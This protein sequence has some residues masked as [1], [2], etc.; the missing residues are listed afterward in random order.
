MCHFV[1]HFLSKT[2]FRR[3]LFIIVFESCYVPLCVTFL[4]ENYLS[5]F[6]SSIYHRFRVLLC[7]T[8][9]HISYRKLSIYFSIFYLSSFSI[10]KSNAFMISSKS[11]FGLSASSKLNP[12]SLGFGS[13]FF[14]IR[15]LAN[16]EF[17]SVSSLLR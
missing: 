12:L 13:C 5:T 3:F 1:P 6:Q 14:L 10:K 15:F 11:S 4:I 16:T 8:S 2:T 7:A 17:S 9:C